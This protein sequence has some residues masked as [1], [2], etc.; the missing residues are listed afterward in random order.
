MR[1]SPTPSRTPSAFERSL[2]LRDERGVAAVEFALILPVLVL[3]L[4]AILDWGYYFYMAETVVNAAREGARVGVIQS[5]ESAA[6]TQAEATA[7]AYLAAAGID[8]GASPNQATV[9]STQPAVGSPNMTVTVAVPAF[10][11]LTGFLEPPL[12]P[13]GITYASTMRWELEP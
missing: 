5:T 7:T 3:L 10:E 2:R 4:M 13:T 1:T 9:D 11:S 6:E 12:I 8:V